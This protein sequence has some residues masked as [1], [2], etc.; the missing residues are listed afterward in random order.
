[1]KESSSAEESF[2]YTSKRSSRGYG[3]RQYISERMTEV[4]TAD[5]DADRQ[6]RGQVA[7]TRERRRVMRRENLHWRRAE[8]LYT[9]PDGPDDVCP[10]PARVL[11]LKFRGWR[12]A[13]KSRNSIGLKN[14][15]VVFTP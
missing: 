5:D 14:K 3:R 13:I 4:K 11:N 12:R 8:R 10:K 1:M 7:T 2:I 6:T 15:G 9:Q